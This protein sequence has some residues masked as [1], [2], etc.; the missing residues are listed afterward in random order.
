ME[1]LEELK[2]ALRLSLSALR[3]L[4]RG[5]QVSLPPLIA[6]LAE[7]QRAARRRKEFRDRTNV[8]GLGAL[9]TAKP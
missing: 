8:P 9:K 3:K 5:E 1:E 4:Q 2:L 7:I 6:R